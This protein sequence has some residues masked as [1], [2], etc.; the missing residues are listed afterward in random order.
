MLQTNQPVYFTCGPLVQEAVFDHYDGK[1]CVLRTT[2]GLL[3][4]RAAR[5][6]TADEADEKG[7][8]HDGATQRI[9]SAFAG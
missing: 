7:L 8:L 3:T 2:L 5:V 4:L 9:K 6:F 1:N